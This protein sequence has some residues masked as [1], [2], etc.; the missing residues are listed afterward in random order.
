MQLSSADWAIEETDNPFY[1]DER[2]FYKVAKWTKYGLKIDRLLYAGNDLDK[3][4]EMFSTVVKHRPQIRLTIRQR[5][6]VLEEWPQ[7][8]E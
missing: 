2:N 6:T 4:R 5:T 1:A 7:G 8:D 3:A